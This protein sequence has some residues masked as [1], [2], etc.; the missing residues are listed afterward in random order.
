MRKTR[1]EVYIDILNFLAR[2]GPSNITRIVYETMSNHKKVKQRMEFLIKKNL[3]RVTVVG[4]RKFY[5]ITERG[6]AVLESLNNLEN[7]WIQLVVNHPLGEPALIERKN[8]K[9][10]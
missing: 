4:K 8:G 3:V 10:A 6:I 7:T 9:H 2:C 5:H 1:L